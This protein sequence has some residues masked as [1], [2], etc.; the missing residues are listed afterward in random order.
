M[1]RNKKKTKTIFQQKPNCRGTW[2]TKSEAACV[3]S[4]FSQSFNLL[5]NIFGSRNLPW[6]TMVASAS[7][8]SGI[9]L[10]VKDTKHLKKTLH[11]WAV[12]VW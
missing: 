10:Q 8:T 12:W 7:S 5:R 11:I 3:T 9:C 6:A 2:E 1:I 4:Y